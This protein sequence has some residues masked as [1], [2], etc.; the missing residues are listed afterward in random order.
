MLILMVAIHPAI[1]RRRRTESFFDRII[2]ASFTKKVELTPVHLLFAK[3][4]T[5]YLFVFL[6]FI[7]RYE[8]SDVK[9]SGGY[10]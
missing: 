4:M 8:N 10:A 3:D 5:S 7:L 1:L 6:Y 9:E 2:S